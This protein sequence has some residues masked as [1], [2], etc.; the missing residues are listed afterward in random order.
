MNVHKIERENPVFREKSQ[1]ASEN[2]CFI[3]LFERTDRIRL[4]TK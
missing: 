4:Y 2:A 1:N 3:E